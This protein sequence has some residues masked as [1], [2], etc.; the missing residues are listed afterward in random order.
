M[1][2]TNRHPVDLTNFQKHPFHL[3]DPSPKLRGGVLTRG[4]HR[5]G[6][7]LEKQQKFSK[8]MDDIDNELLLL[9]AQIQDAEQPALISQFWALL[10]TRCKLSD[11]FLRVTRRLK[12]LQE[13][14]AKRPKK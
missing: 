1:K 14:L 4:I 5:L 11:K 6:S 9:G 2:T 12:K 3:V 7:L 8:L 10:I 13:E